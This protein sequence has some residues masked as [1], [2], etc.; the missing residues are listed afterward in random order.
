MG[1]KICPPPRFCAL[2]LSHSLARKCFSDASRNERNRPLAGPRRRVNFLQ[3]PGEKFLG[4]ILGVIQTVTLPPHERVNREPVGA[5]KF[6]QGVAGVGVSMLPGGNH[7]R[8]MGGDKRG[9]R[10]RYSAGGSRAGNGQDGSDHR[11]ERNAVSAKNAS[12]L[13]PQMMTL[14]L[15]DPLEDH[16]W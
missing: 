16:C 1:I 7:E 9:V 8:P 10:R 14:S 6:F 12:A 13:T 4:Q 2:A 11:S 5:A 3:Q 15:L